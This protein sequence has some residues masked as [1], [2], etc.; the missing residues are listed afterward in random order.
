M[1]AFEEPGEDW[2][3]SLLIYHRKRGEDIPYV[4]LL[5]KRYFKV[6]F[7]RCLARR[8]KSPLLELADL[9]DKDDKEDREAL[10]S[11][12][13]EEEEEEEGGEEL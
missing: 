5:L 9:E 4:P 7:H 3:L 6:L 1:L 12:D 10:L 11:S 2:C 13:P 8:R